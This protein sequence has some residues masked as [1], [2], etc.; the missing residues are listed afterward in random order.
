[1]VVARD[2]H[3][4]IS[5]A[6]HIRFGCSAQSQLSQDRLRIKNPFWFVRVSL[7]QS[8]LHTG[9]HQSLTLTKGIDAQRL[10]SWVVFYTI[11]HHTVSSMRITTE[12]QKRFPR[13]VKFRCVPHCLTTLISSIDWSAKNQSVNPFAIQLWISRLSCCSRY[14]FI[15]TNL[16]PKTPPV[17]SSRLN[18]HTHTQANQLVVQPKWSRS[19]QIDR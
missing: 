18:T 11:L 8:S 2:W 10:M 16:H 7:T 4:I 14:T 12:T 19:T 1:M 13:D 6:N 9:C 15:F 17:N 3:F 5:A